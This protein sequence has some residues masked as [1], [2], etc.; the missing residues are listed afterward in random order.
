MGNEVREKCEKAKR[1][2]YGMQRLGAEQKRKA[3]LAMAGA[4]RAHVEK[5]MEANAKDMANAKKA[6]LDTQMQKRLELTPAKIEAMAKGLEE[7]ANVKDPIGEVV[8]EWTRPSGIRIKKIRVPLGCLGII[9]ESRPN[10][11]VEA[12]GIALK[13]GNSV[14]LRGGKEAINSNIALA[15]I[16][17]EA[18]IGAG[19]PAGCVEIIEN[20]ARESAVEMMHMKGVLDVL[21]PRGGEGLIKT[22]VEN[23]K[24]PVIETGA[25]NCHVFVDKS[26]N[27][28]WA[29]AIIL[30]A[31]CQS[32]YVCN[33][34]E[35]VLVHRD[36]AKK[37]IPRIAEKLAAQGVEI[38]ADAEAKQYAKGSKLATEEDWA[39]E[40]LALKIGI[41]VLGSV[42]EAVE[43]INKYGT[44]HSDSIIT[45]DKA[46]AEYFTWNVDSCTVYVNTSTRFTDGSEFGFGGEMGISTQKLHARGPLG[47]REMTTTKYVVTSAGAIRK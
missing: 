23:A 9:Y 8:E 22:V 7:T 13:A 6:G 12:A 41:K 38:V 24:L 30:N 11:T 33:A 32:P 45:E 42:Q 15:H 31:K 28:D 47:V 26:G 4:L 27:L 39:H 25:G 21:V 17:S 16:I 20:T 36:L 34:L 35:K 43:H 19:M 2:A 44:H 3:L 40:F 14:V 46:N 1:A 29:E 18:G 37:F 5:I 10:V